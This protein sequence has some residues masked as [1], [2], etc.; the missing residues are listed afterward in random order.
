[1]RRLSTFVKKQLGKKFQ[2]ELNAT[3]KVWVINLYLYQFDYYFSLDE[4]EEEN[5]MM[6]M[7]IAFSPL[8]LVFLCSVTS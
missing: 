7:K 6:K 2:M 4:A 1:M 3:R 5:A 8:E